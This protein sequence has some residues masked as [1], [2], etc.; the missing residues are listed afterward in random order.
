VI[1]HA[2]NPRLRESRNA[3]GIRATDEQN[4]E[5]HGGTSESED[6]SANTSGWTS[7]EEVIDAHRIQDVRPNIAHI[8]EI[9]ESGGINDL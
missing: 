8:C 4:C 9:G 6:N 1:R 7:P 3:W 2:V 5:L